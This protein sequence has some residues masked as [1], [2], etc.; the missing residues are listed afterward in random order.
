MSSETKNIEADLKI[1]LDNII[2]E[3]EVV[4]FAKGE[5]E[6]PECGFSFNMFNILKKMNVKFYVYNVMSN[7]AEKEYI[8][9]YSNWPTFPQ[10]YVKK[11][12]IGGIDIVHTMEKSG[13][14]KKVLKN[15]KKEEL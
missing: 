15:C 7:F 10:L 2:S 14:L 11:E 12:L 9:K 6:Q 13:E 4:V 8:K 3:N 1:K 5:K